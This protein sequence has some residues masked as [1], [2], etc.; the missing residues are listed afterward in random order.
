MFQSPRRRLL[1]SPNYVPRGK[2][3]LVVYIY[4]KDSEWFWGFKDQTCRY[5]TPLLPGL[6]PS[7]HSMPLFSAIG[8]GEK[9]QDDL[10]ASLFAIFHTS[11][12]LSLP[13]SEIRAGKLLVDPGHPQE[14]LVG[15]R[16]HHH[17]IKACHRR[18]RVDRVLQKNTHTADDHAK[19]LPEASFSLK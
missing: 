16:P 5:R 14:E 8:C 4:S 15:G 2:T 19:K 13:E 17:Y 3:V 1:L 9:R 7:S 11:S 18:P 12:L 10:S 6:R